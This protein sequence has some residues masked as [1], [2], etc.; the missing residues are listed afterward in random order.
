MWLLSCAALFAAGYSASVCSW[1]AIK[2][3]INLVTA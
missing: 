2:I 3:W 1:A